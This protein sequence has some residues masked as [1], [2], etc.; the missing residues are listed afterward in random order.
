M[1]VKVIVATTF[2]TN[3]KAWQ[4]QDLLGSP[5]GQVGRAMPACMHCV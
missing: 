1:C 3:A 5:C 4:M 2:K